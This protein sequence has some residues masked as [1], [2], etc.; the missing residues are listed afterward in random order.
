MLDEWSAVLGA[1][2]DGA[3]AWSGAREIAALLEWPVE[4][5]NEVLSD[6]SANGLVEPWG[7]AFTLTPLSAE[8]LKVHIVERGYRYV[9]APLFDHGRPARSKAVEASEAM[10]PSLSPLDVAAAREESDRWLPRGPF[11]VDRLPRPRVIVTGSETTWSER[12]A[13]VAGRRYVVKMAAY[14]CSACRNSKMDPC[15]YCLRCDRWGL[16]GLVA[17]RRRA[18]KATSSRDKAG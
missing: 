2:V 16:D 17:A 5:V 18:A 4:Y 14:A 8:G 1:V 15:D 6:L 10:D 7:A 13:R 3:R 11:D 9:W 12:P